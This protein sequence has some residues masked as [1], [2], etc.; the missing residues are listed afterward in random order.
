MVNL[1]E[2]NRITVNSLYHKNLLS[3]L[4]TTV[5]VIDFNVTTKG[6]VWGVF[7]V[8]YYNPYYKKQDRIK[9]DS[10][11]LIKKVVSYRLPD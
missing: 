10:V 11:L 1:I 6:S 5:L 2:Q 4:F 9:G 7:E 3:I 8:V